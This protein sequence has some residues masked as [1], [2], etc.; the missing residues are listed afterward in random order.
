ML[1]RIEVPLHSV[2]ESLPAVLEPAQQESGVRG[3]V[4]LSRLGNGSSEL[5]DTFVEVTGFVEQLAALE[6]IRGAGDRGLRW[7]L[8]LDLAKQEER[9]DLAQSQTFVYEQLAQF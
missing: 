7:V 8:P 2:L 1:H 5:V 6:M 9:V 3:Q 4:S